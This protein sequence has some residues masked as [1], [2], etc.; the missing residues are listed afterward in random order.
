[1]RVAF[2][3]TPD[4]AVNSLRRLIESGREIVAV[5]CQ[6]DKAG[7]RGKISCCAVKNYAAER[8]LK[9]FQFDSVSREGAETLRALRPDVI[10]TCAFGQFL[11]EEILSLAPFG[12]INVH[13]SLLPAYRG[14]SPV[15]SALI[16]GE[17]VTGVTIMRTVKKMDAGD[18]ILSEE[19]PVGEEENFGGLFERLSRVGARLLDEALTLLEK[20]NAVFMPQDDSLATYCK[21]IT[22]EP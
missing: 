18:I 9:V 17:T 15:Q 12:V 2:F 21:N 19:V 14:A 13:A 22:K 10:V 11:S 3:G 16:N 6:P 7:N 5:V 20:G 1:M 8:G 4:F